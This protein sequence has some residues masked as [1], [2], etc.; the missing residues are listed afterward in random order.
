MNIINDKD[1]VEV[2]KGKLFEKGKLKNNEKVIVFDLDET[3]GSFTDLEILYISINRVLGKN[4]IID[5]SDLLNLYPEFLR[6]DIIKILKYIYNKKRSKDCHKLYLYTNN[7]S[8]NNSVN[9][10]IEYFTKKIAKKNDILFDQIIYAF[11]INNQII[12][13]GRSSHEKSVK[14]LIRCTLLPS[15]TAICYIDDHEFDEMKKEKIYYIQPKPYHH[16]LSSYNII[17]RLFESDLKY[18]LN[19]YKN[20][21]CDVFLANSIHSKTYRKFNTRDEELIKHQKNISKKIMYHIKE[22]FYLTKKKDYTKKNK[23]TFHNFTR[24]RNKD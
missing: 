17:S 9:L 14:D 23:K 6:N 13:V 22:F 2:Y 18:L 11:K 7:Q 16:N 8:I 1:C 4:T 20:Q 10:I 19:P 24:K 15:N 12:Q 5:F 21:I 3:L